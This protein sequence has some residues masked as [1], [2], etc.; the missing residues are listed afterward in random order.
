MRE[1][2]VLVVVFAPLDVLVQGMALTARTW[3]GI[4]VGV[5]ALFTVGV[6][7]ETRDR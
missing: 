2:A 7:I 1:I 6:W 4:I 3:L 5:L